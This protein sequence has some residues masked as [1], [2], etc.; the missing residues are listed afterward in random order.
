M[1]VPRGTR[2]RGCCAK[3]GVRWD[4][5]GHWQSA[6]TAPRLE[7]RLK[8]GDLL[9]VDE[10]GMLDQDSAAAL[11]QIADATGARLALVGD[12]QAARGG[13]WRRARSCL[14]LRS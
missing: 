6:E 7:A 10:A 5:H 9:V 14:P 4:D 3:Y 1:S 12:R 11:V 13:S 8:P 2:S